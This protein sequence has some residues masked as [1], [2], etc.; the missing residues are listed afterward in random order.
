MIM[1]F[2]VIVKNLQSYD[3]KKISVSTP[4]PA[5]WIA[6]TQTHILPQYIAISHN[7][8]WNF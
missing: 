6:L 1:F 7:I 4:N 2:H 3:T 8:L 5:A